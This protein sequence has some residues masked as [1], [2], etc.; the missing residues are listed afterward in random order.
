MR[1]PRTVVVVVVL[2][3]VALCFALQ[4]LLLLLLLFVLSS[5]FF[6]SKDASPSRVS[7]SP[8]LPISLYRAPFCNTSDPRLLPRKVQGTN[9][10]AARCFVAMRGPTALKNRAAPLRRQRS[11]HRTPTRPTTLLF[12]PTQ[13]QPQRRQNEHNANNRKRAFRLIEQALGTH[14][15]CEQIN[16]QSACLTA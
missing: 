13:T 10:A 12:A 16:V 2:R 14:L 3:G 11:V 5:H 8:T 6:R 1:R 15:V 7:L 4:L 9:E